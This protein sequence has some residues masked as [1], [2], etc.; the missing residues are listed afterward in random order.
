AKSGFAYTE[1][2]DGH[3]G[4]IPSNYSE[5]SG[6]PTLNQASAV[7]SQARRPP[8]VLDEELARADATADA[9]ETGVPLAPPRQLTVERQLANSVLIGWLPPVGTQPAAYRVYVDGQFFFSVRAVD[10]T[11]ALI[12][13]ADSRQ[14]HRICVRAVASDGAASSRDLACTLV[15]GAS[16]ETS[17]A[18][19]YLQ[20]SHVTHASAKLLFVP[21]SSSLGHVVLLNNREHSQCPPGVY[22]LQ[23][24]GLAADAPYRVC[25]RARAAV[26]SST[27][28]ASAL[29]SASLDFR[30]GSRGRPDPP[31]DVTAEPGPQDGSLLLT[32][33]PVGRRRVDTASGFPESNGCRVTGYAVYADCRH[34]VTECLDANSDHCLL[35]SSS[36]PPGCTKLTVRTVGQAADGSGRTVE[37]ADSEPH[38]ELKSFSTRDRY[39]SD[40]ESEYDD[41][42]LSGQSGVFLSGAPTIIGSRESTSATTRANSA[43]A[44]SRT[45]SDLA[46][47]TTT[48]AM[49]T[50]RASTGSGEVRDL[51]GA[52]RLR[53]GRY[54]PESYAAAVELAFKEGQLIKRGAH[55]AASGRLG[56]VAAPNRLTVEPA[57]WPCTIRPKTLSPN[58]EYV[59]VIQRW[60]VVLPWAHR[61]DGFLLGSGARRLAGPGAQ[62]LPPADV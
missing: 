27:A 40:S 56:S 13:G 22:K 48:T 16:S 5:P 46:A 37:S 30:T 12:E 47:T 34:R 31:M 28:A 8:L 11:K 29:L 32:W 51:C 60:D 50:V 33:L 54:E 3:H 35:A 25:V 23:L 14:R 62:Q 1:L 7:A 20:V 36:L 26:A 55:G 39:Y 49:T 42:Y 15:T 57:W 21:A 2:S 18:P 53:S 44:S 17:L 43:T 6:K 58:A 41:E 24:A 4:Y 45:P 59:G 38:C 19:T 10:K 61:R 9:T 52:V